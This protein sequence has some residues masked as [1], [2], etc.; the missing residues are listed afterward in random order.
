MTLLVGLPESSM[1]D[2]SVFPHGLDQSIHTYIQIHPIDLS[3][4]NVEE[5]YKNCSL[6]M[7]VKPNVVSLKRHVFIEM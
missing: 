1:V 3:K 4:K 5:Y 6:R 2:E 7:M